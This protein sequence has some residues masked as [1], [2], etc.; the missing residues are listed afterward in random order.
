MRVQCRQEP[1]S[2]RA[3]AIVHTPTF[4]PEERN[5]G[6][7]RERT[8]VALVPLQIAPFTPFAPA[9]DPDADGARQTVD[10]ELR[11]SGRSVK[12]G[13]PKDNKHTRSV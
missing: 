2:A 10:G 13:W 1:A 7:R 3:I 5:G 11:V 9:T 4:S 6:A 8:G 12:V